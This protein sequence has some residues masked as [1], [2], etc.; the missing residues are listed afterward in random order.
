MATGSMA[1]PA[2]FV[3]SFLASSSSAVHG[4][5]PLLDSIQHVLVASRSSAGTWPGIHG[6]FDQHNHMGGTIGWRAFMVMYLMA[7]VEQ[8]PAAFRR[9]ILQH[10]QIEGCD[11]LWQTLH[12]VEMFSKMWD[13]ASARA[14]FERVKPFL[15]QGICFYVWLQGIYLRTN[16]CEGNLEKSPVAENERTDHR[17][18]EA[19]LNA[20][21]Q[22]AFEAGLLVQQDEFITNQNR[23]ASWMTAGSRAAPLLLECVRQHVDA[24]RRSQSAGTG[25]N[26]HALLELDRLLETA[27]SSSQL[28]D[29]SSA[30]VTR[31]LLENY[32]NDALGRDVSGIMFFFFSVVEFMTSGI[33]FV[34]WSSNGMMR[35]SDYELVQN[36]SDD[37]ESVHTGR[38]A[39]LSSSFWAVTSTFKQ[40]DETG[41][42]NRKY[43]KLVPSCKESG[44]TCKNI[45]V[46]SSGFSVAQSSDSVG[47]RGGEPMVWKVL[48]Q[49][50]PLEG[51]DFLD[52]ENMMFNIVADDELASGGVFLEKM[53]DAVHEH[54]KRQG[55]RLLVHIHC[56][57]GFP[58]YDYGRMGFPEDSGPGTCNVDP[59]DTQRQRCPWAFDGPHYGL[60]ASTYEA[61]CSNAK[62]P[63]YKQKPLP[64]RMQGSLPMHYFL[65]ERNLQQMVEGIKHYRQNLRMRG[66]GAL[67][68]FDNYVLV[69]FGH[70]THATAAVAEG[71]H[72]E[73]IWTD[74]DLTS[75]LATNALYSLSPDLFHASRARPRYLESLSTAKRELLRQAFAQH[76][77]HHLWSKRVCMVLGTDGSGVQHSHMVQELQIAKTI[78][79]GDT[80]T[81]QDVEN[82][83]RKTSARVQTWLMQPPTDGAPPLSCDD[84]D[85]PSGDGNPSWAAWVGPLLCSFAAITVVSWFL[86]CRPGSRKRPEE[87]AVQLA[88]VPPSTVS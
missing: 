69:S 24:I 58:L 30:Y 60:Q 70:S 16:G 33:G 52:K 47:S 28:L 80:T 39:G 79:Q 25:S 63:L 27:F 54:A 61:M 4:E 5:H 9:N 12:A 87:R 41:N 35:R 36:I 18:A 19:N 15:K 67:E 17:C 7:S 40:L 56:G 42:D 14:D 72:R 29:F 48:D 51:L 13:T 11:W 43:W 82:H 88:S 8:R 76:G 26:Q 77:I 59:Q 86:C 83:F 85:D 68:D 6:W 81:S 57:E 38:L 62:E 2:A 55:K 49:S 31:K 20:A 23:L 44:G 53:L 75:N 74:V 64:V 22:L 34:L 78:L 46:G 65:A 45:Q 1:L 32:A 84:M 37:T 10:I 71:M 50:T 73:R 3:H 66:Q 21:L